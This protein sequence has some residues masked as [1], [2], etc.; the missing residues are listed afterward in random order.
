MGNGKEKIFSHWFP[1]WKLFSINATN[2]L[3]TKW[4][5]P[6]RYMR[7]IKTNQLMRGLEREV[8]NKHKATLF[9]HLINEEGTLCQG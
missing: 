3:V 7:G 4:I 9:S 2:Y 8:G 6:L 5:Y 1:F